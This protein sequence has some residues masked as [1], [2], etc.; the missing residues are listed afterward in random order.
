MTSTRSP[1]TQWA[2]LVALG[3]YLVV[4]CLYS[5][6]PA[7]T[8]GTATVALLPGQDLGAHFL[9]YGLLMAL[10]AATFAS[11]GL[12][13]FWQVTF[14]VS[15]AV[16]ANV[17][18]EL[19]QWAIPWRTMAARDLLAGFAGTALVLLGWLVLRLL[20]RAFGGGRPGIKSGE[21]AAEAVPAGEGEAGS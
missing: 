11:T 13:P 1:M 17:F 5:V 9:A 10:L 21:A 2:C 18:I 12:S 8:P 19:V 14:A 7:G 15:I 4:L 3:C 20:R 6:V 16:G